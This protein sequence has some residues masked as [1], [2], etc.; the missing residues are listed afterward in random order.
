MIMHIYISNLNDWAN[1]LVVLD[2]DALQ[3][4]ARYDHLQHLLVLGKKPILKR[5]YEEDEDI[6]TRINQNLQD[7]VSTINKASL[8]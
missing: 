5:R 4:D 7:I 6:I 1:F 3:P 8:P 2:Q